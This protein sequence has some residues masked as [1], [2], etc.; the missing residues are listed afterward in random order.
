MKWILE[1]STT[2]HHH[3]IA[4]ILNLVAFRKSRSDQKVALAL[5]NKTIFYEN[6]INSIINNRYYNYY[7]CG[8]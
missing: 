7:T 3:S 1:G 8:M 4:A 5:D 2:I 6:E